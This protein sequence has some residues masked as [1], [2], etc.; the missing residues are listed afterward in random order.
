MSKLFNPTFRISFGLMGLTI[1]LILS[2]YAFGLIPDGRK[3]EIDAR[4]KIVE[5]L[6]VQLS[7]AA[8]RNDIQS[9]QETIADVV[10]R[11]ETILSI[12]LRRANGK[13]QIAAGDHE[14][15]WIEPD[16][17]NSTPTHLQVSLTNGT[18]VW[19][20]IEFAFVPLETSIGFAGIPNTLIAFIVFLGAV[21]FILYYILLRRA[22]REID[23][24]NVIPERVRAAF[25]TLAEGVL[26]LDKHGLIL[27]ANNSFA[28]TINKSPKALFGTK[29]EDLEWQQMSDR[30][31]IIEHPWQTALRD[32]KPIKAI[33]M[34]YLFDDDSPKVFLVNATCILDEK[35]KASGIIVTFD[36]VTALEKKNDDLVLAIEKLQK[37]EDEIIKQNRE[38]QYLANHDPLTGCLN[39]RAFFERFEIELETA[40]LANINFSCFMVDLDHFKSINDTFGHAIGDDVIAGMGEILKATSGKR[41]L[42]GRYGGEEFCVALIGRSRDESQWIA[43]NIR[44]QMISLSP[45]WLKSDRYITASIGVA[46]RPKNVCSVKALVDWA[47]KA[48]YEAKDTGRNKV[49]FWDQISKADAPE[50]NNFPEIAARQ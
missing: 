17:H 28:N 8:S 9:I 19:G 47:D 4:A 45:T 39:R 14:K 50:T 29:I 41:S 34:G 32:Q 22:L 18:T 1:S 40:S 37:S 43:D 13:V 35:G 44:E 26:I 31:S 11:N 25:N 46:V 20:K 24:E 49:V 21:G 12:A 48:L 10:K 5:A 2:A 7:N 42:V 16:N 38:L 3:V 36:D 23:P 27:L 15:H 33:K 6:A 30:T